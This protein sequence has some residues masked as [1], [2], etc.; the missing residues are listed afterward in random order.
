MDFHLSI[1]ALLRGLV[2]NTHIIHHQRGDGPSYLI[3][4][5]RFAM[6]SQKNK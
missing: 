3:I 6:R 2:L 1:H 5:L 4:G